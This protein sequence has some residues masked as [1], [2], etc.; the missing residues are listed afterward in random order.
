M[1]G[2][3]GLDKAGDAGG[4]AP[5]LTQQSPGLERG[6]GLLAQRPDFGVG[7]VDPLLTC[8]ELLPA[9][10]LG[11]ADGSCGSLV[12]LVGPAANADLGQGL[13]NAM[14]AGCAKGVN[15]SRQRE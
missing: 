13:E 8:G 15:G 12:S 10:A 7:A 11:H 5:Q 2:E 3:D 6:L 14:F 1:E 4:A 9:T